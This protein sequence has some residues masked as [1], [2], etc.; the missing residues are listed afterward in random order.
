[1]RLLA[2][3]RCQADLANLRYPEY[4]AQETRMKSKQKSEALSNE[5]D[6]FLSE[7]EEMLKQT[8]SLGGDELA[9]AKR[10]IQERMAEAKETVSGI[11]SNLTR[12]ARRA[13]HSANVEAHE[14]PWKIIGAGAAI[15]LL[16]G[17]LL[18]RR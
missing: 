7:M 18:A 4:L 3:R 8:A 6:K 16:L 15:G 17:L 1:M 13:A 2:H 11:R 10:K 9:E 14:E 5:F 12:S